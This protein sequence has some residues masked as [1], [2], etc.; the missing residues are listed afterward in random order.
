LPKGRAKIWIF[1]GLALIAASFLSV[2]AKADHEGHNTLA[3]MA[4]PPYGFIENGSTPRGI[5]Y[6]ILLEV[7]KRRGGGFVIEI[8]PIARLIKYM[9]E[10]RITCSVFFASDFVKS[11]FDEIAP[12][13]WDV[14]S[15]VYARKNLNLKSY[16]DLSGATTWQGHRRRWLNRLDDRPQVP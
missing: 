6:E 4:I 10:G 12:I 2:P 3:A 5:I 1:A 9:T 14:K 13:G 7:S 15:V 11:R 16:E 8:V